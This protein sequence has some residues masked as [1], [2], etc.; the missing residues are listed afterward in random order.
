M[1]LSLTSWDDLQHHFVMI[2]ISIIAMQIDE[3]LQKQAFKIS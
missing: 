2:F 3:I 1:R